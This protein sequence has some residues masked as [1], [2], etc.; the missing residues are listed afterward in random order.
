MGG[1]CDDGSL[2]A[3]QESNREELKNILNEDQAMMQ[4]C[5]SKIVD[6]LSCA[7]PTMV[8]QV[9]INT[10]FAQLINHGKGTIFTLLFLVILYTSTGSDVGS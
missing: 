6:K 3:S 4:D 10:I 5:Y 1:E 7:N 2:P 9:C 8:L